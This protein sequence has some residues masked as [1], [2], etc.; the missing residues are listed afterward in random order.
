MGCLT[1]KPLFNDF[2]IGDLIDYELRY[3]E[4]RILGEGEFGVVHLVHDVKAG[5]ASEPFATKTLR[6]RVTFKDNTIFTPLKPEILRRECTILRALAG[7][8]YILKLI[9]IYE[10]TN[11]IHIVTEYCAGGGVMEYVAEYYGGGGGETKEGKIT[12]G[13]KV[14][15]VSRI[16]CQLLSAVDHCASHGIIHRDIKV[17]FCFPLFLF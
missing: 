10:T 3:L 9:G 5:R 13:M 4:G 8:N 2:T 16:S 6:K 1:S 11:V 17:R 15:D 12:D 7:Q 14:K